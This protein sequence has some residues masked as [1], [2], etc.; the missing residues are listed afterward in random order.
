LLTFA[1]E[2]KRQT[3][4][5]RFILG[6]FAASATALLGC[7]GTDKGS[8]SMTDLGPAGNAAISRVFSSY[9]RQGRHCEDVGSHG[10]RILISGFGRFSGAA[11]NISG[12]VIR[13]M[14]DPGF[15][16]SEFDSRSTTAAAGAAPQAGHL[17]AHDHGGWT[18][19]RT[20]TID[21]EIFEVCFVLVD[22]LWD[23]SA[24]IILHEAERF[25]PDLILMT[26]RGAQS[27]SATI[28]AGALNVASA[29]AGFAADGQ[30]L[31]NNSPLSRWVLPIPETGE[32][33]PPEIAMTW[34]GAA[35][36]D[37][38]SP[39]MAAMPGGFQVTAAHAARPENTY[40]CNNVSYVVLNALQGFPVTLAGDLLRLTPQLQE[41]RAGFFHYP[42]Q[43]PLSAASVFGWATVLAKIMQLDS[44]S[45]P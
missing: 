8:D 3:R 43:T 5:R 30:V 25:R 40:I 38:L 45:H 10:R 27:H 19:Q 34:D 11:F 16:P 26:G 12:A 18:A 21:G 41:S 35:L 9:Q 31:A 2:S 7:G 20:L 44:A 24:A 13:S 23:L 6:L 22:V 37:G 15:W 14:A 36:A 4:K 32:T 1:W 29:Q 42:M 39:L 17:S 28:E 33:P